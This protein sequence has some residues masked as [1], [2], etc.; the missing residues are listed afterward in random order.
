[1][2]VPRPDTKCRRCRFTYARH[3]AIG[4]HAHS[5]C[6]DGSG[7]VF[8]RQAEQRAVLRFDRGELTTLEA[9]LRNALHAGGSAPELVGVLRKVRGAL[10]QRGPSLSVAGTEREAQAS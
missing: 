4:P 10:S 8:H 9:V 6:P 3:V 7:R 1:M 2:T 5:H